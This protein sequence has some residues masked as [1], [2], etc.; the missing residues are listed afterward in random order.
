MLMAMEGLVMTGLGTLSEGKVTYFDT[1]QD[2][3]Y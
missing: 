1:L 2:G 3:G